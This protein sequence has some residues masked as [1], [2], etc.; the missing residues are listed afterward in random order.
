MGRGCYHSPVPTTIR[1]SWDVSY[2]TGLGSM[3]AAELAEHLVV[4]RARQAELLRLQQDTKGM[5]HHKAMQVVVEAG[6]ELRMLG[7]ALQAGESELGQR[8]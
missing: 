8:R 5:S 1:Y 4:L 7:M 2:T 3:T 6:K